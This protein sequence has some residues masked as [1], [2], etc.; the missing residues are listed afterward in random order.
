MRQQIASILEEH[1][2]TVNG[3]WA[4]IRQSRRAKE[5]YEVNVQRPWHDEEDDEGDQE[6]SR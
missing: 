3:F 4:D 1:C 6:L 2:P 5:Q